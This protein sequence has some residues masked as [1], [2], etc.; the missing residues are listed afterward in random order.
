M[1]RGTRYKSPVMPPPVDIFLFLLV[2]LI[3]SFA[4]RLRAILTVIVSSVVATLA[5]YIL[6]IFLDSGASRDLRLLRL[7]VEICVLSAAGLIA[8]LLVFILR[9]KLRRGS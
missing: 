5:L 9:T 7:L 1:Q 6:R 4:C 3:V 2:G 8:P